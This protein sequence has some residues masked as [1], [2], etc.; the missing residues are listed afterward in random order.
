VRLQFATILKVVISQ[1]LVPRADG[2]GRVPALEV[3]ISTSFVRECIV[4]KDRTK[5]IPNA[6]SKGFTTYGMQIRPVA[7]AARERQAGDLRRG[8]QARIESGRL[9]AALPRHRLDLRLQLE[10]FSGDGEEEKP[11]LDEVDT[12]LGGKNDDFSIDRF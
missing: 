5:E 3:L 7:D 2:N 6:I 9:R 1:R 8:T 12:A 11:E 4:N 10:R